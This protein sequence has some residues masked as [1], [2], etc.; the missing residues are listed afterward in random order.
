MVESTI[1]MLIR[2][3]AL[4]SSGKLEIDVERE[5]TSTAGEIIAKTSFGIKKLRAVHYT[6]FKSN[7]CVGVPYSE[8]MYPMKTLEAKRLGKEIDS[9]SLS[10]IIARKNSVGQDDDDDVSSKQNMLGLFLA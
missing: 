8:F 1:N 6:L 10:L 9:L 3:T 7:R 5:I 2:W 4:I